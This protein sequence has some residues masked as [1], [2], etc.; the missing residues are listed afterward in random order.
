MIRATLFA[1]VL[2]ALVMRSSSIA[3]F[4]FFDEV[5]DTSEICCPRGKK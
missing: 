5:S 4:K 2:L 1:T 3:L